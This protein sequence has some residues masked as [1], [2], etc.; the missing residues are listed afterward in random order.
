MR[1]CSITTIS[2]AL[3]LCAGL[4]TRLRPFTDRVP[5]PLI[6]VLGIP[7]VGFAVEQAR[8]AGVSQ[9]VANV[10]HLPELTRSGLEKWIGESAA[11]KWS[12]E[13]GLLLGSA[14]GIRAALPA[15]NATGSKP[16][17][18][19]NG[20]VL[21]EA[22]LSR[23]GARHAELRR[24]YGVRLTLLMAR[25]RRGGAYRKLRLDAAGERVVEAT[26]LK[27]GLGEW[28]FTG[29]SVMEPEAFAALPLGVP[30]EFV[31]SVL[32]PEI[33]AGRVGVAFQTNA[34]AV[35]LDIGDPTVWA[36]AHFDLMGR[37]EQSRLPEE[38]ERTLR[39][40]NRR[41]CAGVWVDR[42]ARLSL[43]VDAAGPAYWGPWESQREAPT[44]LAPWSV[45]YGT[46]LLSD[47]TIGL[48]TLQCA[49]PA[50]SA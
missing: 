28:F 49:L 32:L 31:P 7:T 27:A 19:L 14:G 43:E 11:L 1:S 18:A 9:F 36:Q 15:L 25:T 42:N 12:D 8:V 48:G 50:P 40:R 41:L 10:H 47:S 29:A 23:L 46:G 34:D 13:S 21:C 37:L 17:F 22:D 24:K 44:K 2:K 16:F 3:L 39:A 4:G 33:A 35:W 45:G 20:D 5:K 38:W 26:E 30:S 6:P